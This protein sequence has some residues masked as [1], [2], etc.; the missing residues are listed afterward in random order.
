MLVCSVS[1]LVHPGGPWGQNGPDENEIRRHL[2]FLADDSLQGR[3]TGSRGEKCAAD[4]IAAHLQQYGIE[5]MGYKGTYFQYVPIH[6][7]YPCASARV[8]LY[9]PEGV[10]SLRM[11][12]DFVLVKAG[13]QTLIPAPAAMAFASYGIVAPEFD[14]ND[15]QNLDIAGK[16]AV[17]LSGEPSSTDPGFFNGPYPTIYSTIEAKIRMAMARGAVGS[18]MIRHPQDEA[19]VDWESIVK[20]YYFP[21]M[22]LANAVSSHFSILV[23][24]EVGAMLFSGAQHSWQ[25]VLDFELDG[26]LRSFPLVALLSFQEKSLQR[27]FWARNVLARIRGQ[28]DADNYLLLS[29]HYDHLGVGKP[30]LGDSIYNGAVDNALGTSGLLELAR[31]FAQSSLK[32]RRS[33][34]FAFLTGEEKGLL[35]S[36]YY[37]DHPVVPLH[38]T[39]ANINMDGLAMFDTFYELIGLGAEFSTLEESMK[40]VAE[41]LG[42]KIKSMP[43]ELTAY[44][45]FAQSDQMAFAEAGIPSVLTTEGLMS[46]GRTEEEMLQL[47]IYWSEHIY[48]SPFDDLHQPINYAA[49]VQHLNFIY[50]WAQELTQGDFIPEWKKGVPFRSARLRTR[51]QKR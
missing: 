45:A 28:A 18:I 31:L 48:H 30:V 37:V 5:P 39:L 42:L 47:R 24:S 16:I 29:A 40:Q 44:N 14:Y 13:T 26:N 25:E 8:F 51:V 49:A 46:A 41:G 2:A 33:I 23:P 21:D 20:E 43:A 17:F 22:T 4:Y 27:D 1:G 10:E 36:R 19:Y 50:T 35:G 7:S 3:E 12:S 34:L 9:R 6:A 15:Y 38:K 11:F 32:P